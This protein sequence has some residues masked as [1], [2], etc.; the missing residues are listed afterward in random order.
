MINETKL[1]D[2][3]KGIKSDL[4]YAPL[5]FVPKIYVK[6]FSQASEFKEG[7]YNIYSIYT[8]KNILIKNGMIKQQSLLMRQ[9]KI[10]FQMVRLSK[11]L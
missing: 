5:E 6:D 10:S 2:S 4:F 8:M 3:S 1:Q 9:L 11:M 7:W